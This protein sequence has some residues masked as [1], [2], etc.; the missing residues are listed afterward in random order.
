MTC[1]WTEGAYT[2]I[3]RI[4]PLSTRYV[5]GSEAGFREAELPDL[6]NRAIL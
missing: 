4:S 2:T 3:V 1:S 6:W 5:R